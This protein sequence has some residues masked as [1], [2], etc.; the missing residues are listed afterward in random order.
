MQVDRTISD[1]LK[2]QAPVLLLGCQGMLGRAW[3]ELLEAAGVEYLP[4]DRPQ[5]DLLRLESIPLVVEPRFRTVINCT[6]Y[7]DVDRAETEE[8]LALALNATAVGRLAECCRQ[9]GAILVHY[10]TDYVFSGQAS[11]PYRPDSLR[12][13]LG[14]YG[15]TKAE[16]ERLAV[17]SGCRLLLIRTSWLYA[18]WAKNFVRTI[19]VLAKT[20]PELKV[21]NDQT[22]RPTSAESLALAT[23][24]LVGEGAEGVYHV[25]DGG[26]CTWYEFAREIAAWANPAC[27]VVPCTTAEFSR[28]APRPA[29]SVLDVSGTESKI[30]ALPPW[31]D[32]LASVLSR[33]E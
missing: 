4:L 9:T 31:Q 22:G 14:A 20:K 7:T 2:Q 30:G 33:L 32:N 16:G 26:Q 6:A 24:K 29:Y 17:E 25:T 5:L 13:P 27:R 12:Q 19:A 23:A 18:P 28:P 15:R 8:A 10:S 21:V 3:R 1:K 11:S